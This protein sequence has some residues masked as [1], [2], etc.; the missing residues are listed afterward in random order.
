MK[1]CTVDIFTMISE[2]MAP[3]LKIWPVIQFTMGISTCEVK[4]GL[5]SY[6]R[7]EVNVSIRDGMVCAWCLMPGIFFTDLKITQGF[8]KVK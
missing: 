5:A 8:S 1:L 4:R 6:E 7:S 2:F 3:Y